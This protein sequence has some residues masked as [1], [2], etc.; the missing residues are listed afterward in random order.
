[1]EHRKLPMTS[2]PI[3]V[4]KDDPATTPIAEW[5]EIWTARNPETSE[6]VLCQRHGWWDETNKQAHFN[7]PVLSEPFKTEPE[8]NTAMDSQIDA[9]GKDGWIH[10]FTIVF[11]P[12]TGG[13]KGV[14][15]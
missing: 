9:L 13:G 11:D 7:V 15:I 5:H 3:T 8:V 6:W 1:M 14:R 12:L 4:Y 2:F 10:K